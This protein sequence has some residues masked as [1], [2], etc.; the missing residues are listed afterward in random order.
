MPK[1][2]EGSAYFGEL[3]KVIFEGTKKIKHGNDW[4]RWQIPDLSFS[5][6]EL[7]SFFR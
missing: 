7:K 2:L 6:R 3:P 4:D 1:H 5:T